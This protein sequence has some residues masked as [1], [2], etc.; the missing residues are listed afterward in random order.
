[1][2]PSIERKNLQRLIYVTGET[3][4]RMPVEIVFDLSEKIEDLQRE[5]E[6]PGT[7]QVRFDG[8]GGWFT[9]R[10]VFRDLGI[11]VVAIYAML[12]YPTGS[13]PV[14]GILLSSI[15]LP[16]VGVLPGFWQLNALL[17]RETAGFPVGIPFT[18]T[19]MIG[20]V[21]L[22]GIAGRNAILLIDFTQSEEAS[23]SVVERVRSSI[24]G[25]E[26]CE[27]KVDGGD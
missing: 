12:V 19:D 10:R 16:L 15:P 3:A 8:E 20:I 5:G 21:A 11:A 2:D 1:M 14:A 18:A 13:Y 24:G 9:T 23:A 7:L 25:M 27:R 6:L 17:T 26:T 4:G 22:A